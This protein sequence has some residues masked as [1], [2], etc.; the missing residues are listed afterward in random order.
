MVDRFHILLLLAGVFRLGLIFWGQYQ[1][2]TGPLPY[3]DID[4][5]VFTDSARCL[6]APAPTTDCTNATGPLIGLY[7]VH[8]G[9]LSS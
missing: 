1:D 8:K 4:Y 9:L 7:D 3:T 2:K 6:L 5:Q